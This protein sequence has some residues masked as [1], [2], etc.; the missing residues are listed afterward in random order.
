M[1]LISL[2]LGL[3]T[4]VAVVAMVQLPGALEDK[5]AEEPDLQP[6]LQVQQGKHTQAEAEA[7]LRAGEI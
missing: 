2:V 5:V 7:G 4:V 1:R 3:F 6:V